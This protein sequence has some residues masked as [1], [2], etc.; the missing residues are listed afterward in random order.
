VFTRAVLQY[1]L[2]NERIETM[3][4]QYNDRGDLLCNPP[5]GHEF[6]N[7]LCIHC[8]APETPADTDK[9]IAEFYRREDER[10]AIRAFNSDPTNR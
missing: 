5:I 9:A 3:K 1:A 7:G 4:K 10:L 6:E 2:T 8:G